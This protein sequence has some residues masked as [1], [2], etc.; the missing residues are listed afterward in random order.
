MMATTY[1]TP[2]LTE[3]GILNVDTLS[4]SGGPIK[5]KA[6]RKALLNGGAGPG[7]DMQDPYCPEVKSS[8]FL[9]EEIC[10]DPRDN[11]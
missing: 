11:I 4:K 6:T 3:L 5:K 1:E 9:L 8:D 10:F 7:Y 2:E